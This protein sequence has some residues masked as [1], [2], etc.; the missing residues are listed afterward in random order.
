MLAAAR[1]ISSVHRCARRISSCLLRLDVISYFSGQG[2][3]STYNLCSQTNPDFAREHRAQHTEHS[4]STVT[5]GCRRLPRTAVEGGEHRAA[6]RFDPSCARWTLRVPFHEY[7]ESVATRSRGVDKVEGDAAPGGPTS[8]KPRPARLECGA[9][10]TAA[11]RP[12]TCAAFGRPR[13]SATRERAPQGDRGDPR[14]PS[15]SRYAS[16]DVGFCAPPRLR[17][18]RRALT[19]VAARTNFGIVHFSIQGNTSTRVRGRSW[20]APSA[21]PLEISARST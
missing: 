12:L 20:S 17:G 9:T 4:C 7:R 15:T 3:V 11:P 19:T 1:R 10:R 6:L 13:K 8:R 21:W 5:H 2:Q 14:N 18:I 16:S